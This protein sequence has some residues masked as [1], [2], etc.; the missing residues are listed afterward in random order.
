MT[1]RWLNEFFKSSNYMV[2][3]TVIPRGESVEEGT[4]FVEETEGIDEWGA[5]ER[6]LRG[7]VTAE[8]V[9]RKGF[10]ILAA[11]K[12]ED[13]DIDVFAGRGKISKYPTPHK[14]PG[15]DSY[16]EKKIEH[17]GIRGALKNPLKAMDSPIVDENWSYIYSNTE[18]RIPNYIGPLIDEVAVGEVDVHGLSGQVETRSMDSALSSLEDIYDEDPSMAEIDIDEA[19]EGDSYYS[20]EKKVIENADKMAKVS[21]D[22]GMVAGLGTYLLAGP[23]FGSADHDILNLLL[24]PAVGST[25]RYPSRIGTTA[26][27]EV[28]ER[29]DLDEYSD[30]ALRKFRST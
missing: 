22:V 12:D 16:R 7:Q 9:S 14:E 27:T 21:G 8:D 15:R 2:N 20:K 13:E 23:V 19:I 6:V 1:Y 5:I 30:N 25:L 29:Y 11:T 24:Y 26:L 28:S 18:A 10:D 3:A 4:H 17:K